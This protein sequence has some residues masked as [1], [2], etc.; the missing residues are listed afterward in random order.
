MAHVVN[1]IQLNDRGEQLG[2]KYTHEF[3]FEASA[4]KW[5]DGFNRVHSLDAEEPWVAVY[6]GE[7]TSQTV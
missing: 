3:M 1:I 5:I 2:V 6:A 4:R 7:N